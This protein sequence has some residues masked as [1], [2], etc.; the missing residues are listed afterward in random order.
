[1]DAA[2]A[3]ARNAVRARYEDIPTQA[4][5][6]AKLN[7]LDTLGSALA[8]S[9]EPGSREIVAL[10]KDLGGREEATVL[11]FGGRVSALEAC[12]AN[13]A[14]ADACDYSDI[15]EAAHIHAGMITIPAAMA[16]AERMGGVSGKD[17][18]TA[19]VLGADLVCRMGLAM[20]VV[21]ATFVL[22]S[23]YGF[24]GSALTSGKL[25]GLNEDQM[26]SAIGLGYTQS[27]GNKQGV[28]EGDLS[29]RMQA[30]FA[31]RGGLLAAM[32]A[33]RGITG[34]RNAMQ[35]KLGIYNAYHGGQYSPE[36]LTPR[37][38]EHFEGANTS[39]KPYPCCRFVH[40]HID[41]ALALSREHD[42]AADEIESI[43]AF[44]NRQPHHQMEP[45][46]IKRNPRTIV[47]AQFSIPYTTAAALVRRR[48][49]FDDFTPE[50]IK[51]SVVIAVANKVSPVLDLSLCEHEPPAAILEVKTRRGTFRK[52]IEY[53]LGHPLNPISDAAIAEK[54]RDC[55]AHSVNPS[56]ARRV[57]DLIDMIGNLE[58]LADMRELIKLLS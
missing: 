42:I 19:F 40:G 25:L 23:I 20:P 45:L 12:L 33:Q 57:T 26:M 21:P 46:D 32:M 5:K 58:H 27:S 9:A 38:G 52:R 41:A 16:L 34:P 44:V 29:K 55:A 22:S 7:L 1:M 28:L 53:P 47:D 37:L 31:A 35:G 56:S 48:V 8:G 6:V 11:A 30:G 10:V 2:V 15:H 36:L 51:D 49:T 50:A 39:F 54:F 4:I 3:F 24:L 43:G 18:L 17:F 13:G 14:V